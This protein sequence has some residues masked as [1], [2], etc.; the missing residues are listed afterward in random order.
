MGHWASVFVHAACNHMLA[1]ECLCDKHHPQPCARVPAW[2]ALL[3]A[4]GSMESPPEGGSRP[5]LATLIGPDHLHCQVIAILQQQP[6]A[7]P[8][9]SATAGAAPATGGGVI[10]WGSPG[11]VVAGEVKGVGY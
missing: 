8:G 11:G 5:H 3:P 6:R 4:D 9:D 10:S 1:T 2:W 7:Q